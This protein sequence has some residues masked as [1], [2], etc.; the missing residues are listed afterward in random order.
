MAM[1]PNEQALWNVRTQTPVIYNHHEPVKVNASTIS[2]IDL[3]P[4]K[5]ST[6]A[7]ANKEVVLILTPLKDGAFHI[8]QH[9]DLLSQ[10]TY[11]H[12]L[13]D[14]AFLVSDSKDDTL[15][16]LAKELDRIQGRDDAVPFRSATIVKKDFGFTLSQNVKER[17]GFKAQGPRR[18]ALGKARN[19]LLSVALKPE[20][21]WVYWRDVDIKDSPK[22]IIED[23]IAHD[24]DVIVPS[25]FASGGLWE[26][27]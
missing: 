9:F 4:I 10:L 23:L 17:H 26:L 8:E 19:Y 21:S 16:I 12:D 24:R 18:K 22:T 3:N 25:E 6:K 14:L 2:E 11:P 13:I 20:H 15:A 5:S 27:Y 1:T 7:V